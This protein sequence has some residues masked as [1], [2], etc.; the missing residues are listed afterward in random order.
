MKHT[1]FLIVIICISLSFLVNI[2]NSFSQGSWDI[3]YFVIDSLNNSFIGKVIRLDFKSND[4]DTLDSVVDAFLVRKLLSNKDTI[5]LKIEGKYYSVKENW[6]VYVDHGSLQDQTLESVDKSVKHRIV[7]KD[8]V[9]V[10]VDDSAIVINA[11]IHSSETGKRTNKGRRPKECQIRVDKTRV[12][13][14]LIDLE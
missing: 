5:T 10:S 7:I 3:D 4:A 6:K 8:M 11:I 14:F 13:G 2:R 1:K 9:L 12:K